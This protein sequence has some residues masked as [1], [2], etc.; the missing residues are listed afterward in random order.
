MT[1]VQ[2]ARIGAVVGL[3]VRIRA[4]PGPAAIRDTGQIKL[5]NAFRERLHPHLH[6]RLEVPVAPGDQRAW[7][8]VLSRFV[9]YPESFVPTEFDSVIVDF[10]AQLRRM[11]L[12]CSDA[13]SEHL[14]WVVAATRRNRTAIRAVR[15]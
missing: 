10:Q 15:T 14:L 1:V 2:L 11:T 5:M 4:Y 6:M 3:D 13:G 12:K 7:D 8:A 9:D